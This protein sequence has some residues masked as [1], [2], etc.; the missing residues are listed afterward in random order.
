MRRHQVLKPTLLVFIRLLGR[1]WCRLWGATVAADSIIHGLPRIVCKGTGRI[2]LE[3]GVTL[4]SATWSNPLN[5]GRRT[6]LFAG[7]NSSIGFGRNSGA[8]SSRIIAHQEIQ[9]GE[10]SLIGAGCLICD[11]DMHEV[12]LGC[13]RPVTVAPI[14]IGSRVFIGANCTILKGVTIGD[15]AV[16]GA[17]SVVTRDIPAGA[18]VAGNPATVRRGGIP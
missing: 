5:D 10:G 16:I 9:I 14:R 2:M 12:P 13:N 4:N 7:P 1:F 8:S 11:S 15:G 18:M 3:S 6:V 17:G